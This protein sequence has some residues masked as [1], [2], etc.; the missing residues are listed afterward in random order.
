MYVMLAALGPAPSSVL[1][2]LQTVVAIIGSALILGQP[3]LAGQIIGGIAILVAIAL[4]AF[5][6]RRE[7]R[8][9]P[10]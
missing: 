10:D 7:S 5:S 9:I 6:T 1:L 3:V 2:S 8:V 4:G